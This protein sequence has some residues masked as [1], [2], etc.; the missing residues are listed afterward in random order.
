MTTG[1]L[2]ALL[3]LSLTFLEK[4]FAFS[5]VEKK[6]LVN[7]HNYYRALVLDASNM[8]RM[9]WDNDLEEIASQYAKKCIWE[10]NKNRGQIGENLYAI[11]ST[12]NLEAAVQKWHSEVIDYTYDTMECTPKKMC[13]HYTQVVWADSE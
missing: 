11:T 4:T 7:A 8:L 1:S 2:K 10:H 5:E 9:K 13:G 3:L 12:V 6:E